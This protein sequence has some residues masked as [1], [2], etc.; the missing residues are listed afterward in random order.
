MSPGFKPEGDR[1][2]RGGVG[3]K[4]RRRRQRRR[5]KGERE[6]ERERERDCRRIKVIHRL[7]KERKIGMV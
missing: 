3:R 5:E 7:R 1:K 2:R 4:R 6:R